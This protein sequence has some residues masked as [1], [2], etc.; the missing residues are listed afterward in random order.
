M[1]APQDPPECPCACQ[2]RGPRFDFKG[3]NNLAQAVVFMCMWW[4]EG[5]EGSVCLAGVGLRCRVQLT[6]LPRPCNRITGSYRVFSCFLLYADFSSLHLHH[7]SYSPFPPK[8]LNLLYLAYVLGYV[9]IFEKYIVSC[10][11]MHFRSLSSPYFFHVMS[12]THYSNL[13]TSFL[14]I[15]FY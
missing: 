1:P 15:Y 5:G 12:F 6:T 13:I 4:G 7:C 2:L 11:C 9:C 10:I 3:T 8:T 14:F